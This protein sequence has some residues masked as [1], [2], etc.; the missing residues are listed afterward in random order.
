M[1]KKK[2]IKYLDAKELGY[3]ENAKV[4]T[5]TIGWYLFGKI[6]IKQRNYY[7]DFGTL[8]LTEKGDRMYNMNLDEL[9]FIHQSIKERLD[10]YPMHK[11]LNQLKS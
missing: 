10:K 1:I 5:V 4:A 6:K 8:W 11:A 9:I 3:K 7:H 2:V